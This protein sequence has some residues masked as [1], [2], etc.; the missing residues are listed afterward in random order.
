ML[1]EFPG[2][3]SCLLSGES[4]KSKPLQPRNVRP[5]TRK[6]FGR[7]L[8]ELTRKELNIKP[9]VEKL[10]NKYWIKHEHPYRKLEAV[11]T[12]S[13]KPCINILEQGCGRTAPLLNKYRHTGAMLHGVD[14][15]DFTSIHPNMNLVK[16][17]IE[18]LPF[19]ADEFDLLVSRSVMEHVNNPKLAYNEAFR[20]LMKGGRWIFLTPNRWD[21]VSIISRLVPNRFHGKV[22]HLTTGR[23]EDDILPVVY[24]SNS[25]WQINDACKSAGF[26]NQTFDYFG[27]HP[28]N[29]G[30]NSLLYR[31]ATV[32]EKMILSTELLMGVRGWLFVGL[33]K[34]RD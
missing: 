19:K 27:Q 24:E 15:V 30:F 10:Y 7:D 22:V 33:E 23:E 9:R 34:P 21:Y 11:L 3:P 18:D 28:Q 17:S 16:S 12:E 8:L 1:T 25:W 2:H 13:I 20:V 29:F 4:E 32:Y 31:I 5:F 6:F 14:L 26:R